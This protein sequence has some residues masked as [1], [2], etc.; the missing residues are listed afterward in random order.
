VSLVALSASR[1][2]L[3]VSP[4]RRSWALR[5][6]W[7]PTSGVALLSLVLSGRFA[8]RIGT[9]ASTRRRGAGRIARPSWMN[10]SGGRHHELALRRAARFASVRDISGD[11]AA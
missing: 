8:S 11:D 2:A 10:P 4:R 6:R 9:L 7:P 5:R 3:L 1:V